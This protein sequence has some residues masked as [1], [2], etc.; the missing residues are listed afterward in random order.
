MTTGIDTNAAAAAHKKRHDRKVV[1][2]FPAVQIDS[3]PGE[4]EY[5][6]TGNKNHYGTYK[7]DVMGKDLGGFGRRRI[8]VRSMQQREVGSIVQARVMQATK[9]FGNK[10][11]QYQYL[12]LDD[13]VE[14]EIGD[15]EAIPILSWSVATIDTSKY[16]KDDIDIIDNAM[17]TQTIE[18]ENQSEQTVKYGVLTVTKKDN[19]YIISCA[20]KDVLFVEET[21]TML[22]LRKSA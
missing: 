13:F 2:L 17:W 6:H 8:V 9:T 22:P 16:D 10:N 12:A 14:T 20:G 7:I 15:S 3:L 18:C 21:V 1:R 4:W 11:V 5:F 19:P